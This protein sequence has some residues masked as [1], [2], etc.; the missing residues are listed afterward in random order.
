VVEARTAVGGRRTFVEDERVVF[1]ASLDRFL[2]GPD[3]LPQPEDLTFDLGE[4]DL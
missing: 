2:E 3:P 4:F 1:G